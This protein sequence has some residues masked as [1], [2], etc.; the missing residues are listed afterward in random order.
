MSTVARKG[1]PCDVD[2]EKL[3]L[4][5]VMQNAADNL[6]VA[7]EIL[8]PSDFSLEAHQLIFNRVV[9]MA[10]LSEKID[11]MTVIRGLMADQQ[12]DAVGGITYMTSLDDDLPKIYNLDAYCE[13]VAQKAILREAILTAH[14]GIERMCGPAAGVSDV[15]EFQATVAELTERTKTR[16]GGFRPIA[17]VIDN[18]DGG[19]VTNFMNPPM[20]EAGVPWPWAGLNRMIGFLAPGQA[21]VLSAG[22]G[23]GKTTLATQLAL[24]GA[25]LGHCVAILTLEMTAAEQTKKIIAQEGQACLSDWLRGESNKLDRKKI[26]KATNELYQKPLYFDDRD[27][28]T[29]AML[30]AAIERM[31]V[32][33][34]VVIVDYVQLMDSGIRD[35]GASREQH[36]AHISRS[37]K[38]LAKRYG[39]AFVLLSQLNDQG[40]TRESRSLE[41]DATFHIKLERQPGGLYKLSCPKARFAAFGHHIE[42]RLHGESGL[43]EELEAM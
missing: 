29:P 5:A 7:T 31:K 35:K 23:V 9:R 6:S 16:R 20:D 33:P 3:V 18:A 13:T 8:Q 43:F 12:L 39:V 41:H 40:Q 10:D 17:E 21:V 30:R 26:Q 24:Y 28:V 1:L 36:V 22:T 2:L 14:A 15:E 25:N 27:D 38:K 34:A 4:G 37:M 42:L 19:G 11:R 32:K